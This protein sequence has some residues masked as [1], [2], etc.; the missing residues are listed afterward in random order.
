MPIRKGVRQGDTLCP[1]LFTNTFQNVFKNLDWDQRGVYI[2]RERLHNLRY[3]DDH[4]NYH[5]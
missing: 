2:N 1:K 5:I 4:D 3:K